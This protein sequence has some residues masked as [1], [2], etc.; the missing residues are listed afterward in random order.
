MN[1]SPFSHLRGSGVEQLTRAIRG[2]DLRDGDILQPVDK[3]TGS[4]GIGSLSTSKAASIDDDLSNVVV[5]S[6]RNV[7]LVCSN[8]S[9]FIGRGC[10]DDTGG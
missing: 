10:T 5:D 9:A 1:P 2:F 6:E 7:G 8:S 4:L 3:L